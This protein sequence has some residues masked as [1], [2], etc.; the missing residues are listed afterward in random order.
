MSSIK[1]K[2]TSWLDIYKPNATDIAAI[3]KKHKFHPLILNELTAP[4]ARARVEFHDDY[5]FIAHHIPIYDLKLK[6]SRKA[7]LD[8]LIRK[9]LIITVRYE[10]LEQ[11]DGFL[12]D[13]ARDPQLQK[14][15]MAGDS[16]LLLHRIMEE[17]M[18]FSMRQLRHIEEQV[19]FIAHNI[20]KREGKML[21]QISRIKRDILD[22]R[23]IVKPHE[24]LFE[25][26]SD[27]GLGLWGRPSSV[28]LNKLVGEN[29]RINQHLENYYQIIES[30]ESTNAQLLGA[31][32]NLVIK[33]F[34]IL[35][36][37]FSI[38]LFFIFS[39]SVHHI[40]NLVNTP[41]K[42]WGI[43]IFIFTAVSTTVWIFRR[44]KML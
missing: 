21:E 43:L 17:I 32:T 9:H 36:F 42:F 25:S 18:S 40:E 38:P 19:E 24:E 10:P 12:Q 13:L 39:M 3:K 8:F 35:A 7:E 14:E 41:A 4:S 29:L 31:A 37:L 23:L 5:I 44:N 11:F 27:A 33:R 1:G 15:L 28:Y 22:Y 34:T 20:F 6:T 2:K 16:Y 26:L 30:L